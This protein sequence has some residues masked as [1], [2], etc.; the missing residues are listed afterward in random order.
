MTTR[1]DYA[2]YRYRGCLGGL[3]A[4]SLYNSS[5]PPAAAQLIISTRATELSTIWGVGHMAMKVGSP[6]GGLKAVGRRTDTVG[7]SIGEAQEGFHF[8]SAGA[9]ISG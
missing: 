7:F 1:E 2:H 9:A 6:K 8:R 5:C 3:P 4:F